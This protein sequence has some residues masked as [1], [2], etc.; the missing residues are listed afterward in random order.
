[1]SNLDLCVYLGQYHRNGAWYDQCIYENIYYL[2]VH[3]MT[4]DLG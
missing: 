4:S 3:L 1:M 2:L